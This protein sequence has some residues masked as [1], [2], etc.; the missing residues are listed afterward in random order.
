M[1]SMLSTARLLE[2]HVLDLSLVKSRI[3]LY[4]FVSFS[5]QTL[6]W[7]WQSRMRD[8]AA[9]LSCEPASR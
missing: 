9:S 5:D 8:A 3:L 7:Q 2:D 4:S 1:L 6:D